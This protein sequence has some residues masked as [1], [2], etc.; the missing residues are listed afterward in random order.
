VP[1]RSRKTAVALGRAPKVPPSLVERWLPS[2]AFN[3]LLLLR[4]APCNDILRG[5]PAKATAKNLCNN[6]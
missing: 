3:A 4:E 2:F 1:T 5:Q 6:G